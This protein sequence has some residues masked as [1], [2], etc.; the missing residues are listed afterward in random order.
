MITLKFIV[1]DQ[2]CVGFQIIILINF[3]GPDLNPIKNIWDELERHIRRPKN[4]VELFNLL[5]EEWFVE[6]VL[7]IANEFW[8]SEISPYKQTQ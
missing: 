2:L 8:S 1:Q 5:E 3:P 6:G 4:E 7:Q